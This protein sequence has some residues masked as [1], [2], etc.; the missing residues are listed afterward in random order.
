MSQINESIIDL[1][2]L[3]TE[4]FYD[5]FRKTFENCLRTRHND[6]IRLNCKILVGS[7]V[8]DNKSERHSTEDFL[9]FISELSPTDLQ[10]GMEIY[11]QQKDKP[12]KF[13]MESDTNT[14]LKF[15]VNNGWHTIQGICNLSED[16][17]KISLYK[18]SRAGLVKEIVGAYVS[19][20]GGL[21]LIT[22]AFQ[23]LM[24]F[25]RYSN[26]PIFYHK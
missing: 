22:P 20:S 10:V 26:E 24:H 25:I 21:Y 1:S 7:I 15:V 8:L 9:S 17:F 5:I 23:K 19:Y 13:D 16:N 12:D 6:K 2:F 18:L 11:K 14:E 3:T 4:E